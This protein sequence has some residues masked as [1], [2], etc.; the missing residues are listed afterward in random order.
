MFADLF[1]RLF[2]PEPEPLPD[3]DARK[4]LA[5]L[6]VRIARADGYYD[7]EEVR[8]IDR[9]LAARYGLSPFEAAGLRTA[10]EQIE[11]GAPDTVRFTRAIKDAVPYQERIGVITALWEIV[12]A[13]GERDQQEDAL[14]RLVAPMLGISD[15]D[16]N[17]ARL[18]VQQKQ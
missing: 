1:H 12:L 16:S 3:D 18:K 4:A 11:A 2:Q 13:D 6:L 8:R 5:A 14:L 7:H 9:L 17:A 15:R 10:A